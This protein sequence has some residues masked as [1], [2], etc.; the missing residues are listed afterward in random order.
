MRYLWAL[1]AICLLASAATAATEH[2]AVP[3]E[4]RD[5]PTGIL[6][7]RVVPLSQAREY[8]GDNAPAVSQP[9]WLQV[10]HEFYRA[11]LDTPSR[12][13]AA[14]L[15]R[16]AHSLSPFDPVPIAVIHARYTAIRDGAGAGAVR[17]ENDR[18][19]IDLGH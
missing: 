9:Q 4:A 18:V 6:Y 10:Y 5:V 7:D 11:S 2:R 17:L 12:P 15:R 8:D 19:R 14:T 13:D 16:R 1:A 3:V